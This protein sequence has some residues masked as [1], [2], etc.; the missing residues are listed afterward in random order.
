MKNII[1][2]LSII[3]LLLAVSCEYDPHAGFYVSSN[4]VDVYETVYFTNTS[5][6]A[7]SFYWDFGDGSFSTLP[8]PSHF[9]EQPGSYLVR[10]KIMNGSHEIDEA[11]MY[12]DVISTSLEIE[13]LEY[14]ERY[15][16]PEASIMLYTT[17]NDWNLQTNPLFDGMEWITD[18]YGM[19]LIHG[20]RPLVYYVDIW[21]P[22][23]N[24]YLLGSEDINNVRTDP[25]VRGEINAY[26][27]YVDYVGSI[28][29]KDGKEI[30]SYKIVKIERKEPGKLAR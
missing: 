6:N 24:N 18:A 16:V 5:S 23:H 11:T 26:T 25:L 27:F 30:T 3:V 20:L 9:Y 13:V 1:C 19:V 8:N 2:I 7:E 21:H 28:N 29:R 22:S 15:P 12:I 17:L 4:P 10:L 14:I